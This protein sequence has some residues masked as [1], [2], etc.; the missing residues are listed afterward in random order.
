MTDN[1]RFYEWYNETYG[2]AFFA[3]E[4]TRC[5]D[6]LKAWRAAKADS[7]KQKKSWKEIITVKKDQDRQTLPKI[8]GEQIMASLENQRPTVNP[9]VDQFISPLRSRM[10]NVV[11]IHSDSVYIRVMGNHSKLDPE[12]LIIKALRIRGWKVLIH[13]DSYYYTV[14]GAYDN[15]EEITKLKENIE[16]AY[17]KLEEEYFQ[18]IE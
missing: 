11:I 13:R 16:T 12:D 1:D 18:S 10:I 15:P 6:C 14:E 9:Y 17:R 8:L 7:K 2:K 3:T 4:V 5:N